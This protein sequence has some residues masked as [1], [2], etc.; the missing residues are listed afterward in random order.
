M[1][2]RIRSYPIMEEKCLDL[3]QRLPVARLKSMHAAFV[4]AGFHGWLY[5]RGAVNA[6]R[7]T[8][9]LEHNTDPL[10]PVVSEPTPTTARRSS[11]SREDNPNPW[12]AGVHLGSLHQIKIPKMLPLAKQLTP[13]SQSESENCQAT[14]SGNE[15]VRTEYR[16]SISATES[17]ELPDLRLRGS[18]KPMV[19]V[20][21]Q[22]LPRSMP[23]QR[24]DLSMETEATPAG[25]SAP[26]LGGAGSARRGGN[27]SGRW[28]RD[29]DQNFGNAGASKILHV[30]PTVVLDNRLLVPIEYESVSMPPPPGTT[31]SNDMMNTST[32]TNTCKP[33]AETGKVEAG[34]SVPLVTANTH[35][36]IVIRIRLPNTAWSEYCQVCSA[37]RRLLNQSLLL[38]D[39][40]GRALQVQAQVVRRE[41]GTMW[42]HLSAFYWMV[43][44]T[45]NPLEWQFVTRAMAGDVSPSGSPSRALYQH[46]RSATVPKVH[47]LMPGSHPL[48]IDSQEVSDMQPAPSK[49]TRSPGRGER[50]TGSSSNSDVGAP[51]V[52]LRFR[53]EGQG[54]PWSDP[55]L[56]EDLLLSGAKQI[57]CE[58]LTLSCSV[59]RAAAPFPGHVCV[60][61]IGPHLLI[62]N[63]LTIPLAVWQMP[64]PELRSS[65]TTPSA[66][67]LLLDNVPSG[68]A[69]H[70][71][72]RAPT[73]RL[74]IA[75]GSTAQEARLGESTAAIFVEDGSSEL[76]LLQLPGTNQ[77]ISAEIAVLPGSATKLVRFGP[78]MGRS[79]YRIANKSMVS[80]AVRQWNDRNAPVLVVP[81]S[82]MD[83]V[84]T[85][86]CE[87]PVV[88]VWHCGDDGP[89]DSAVRIHM[90]NMESIGEMIPLATSRGSKTTSVGMQQNYVI[91]RV[92]PEGFSH[93]MEI[94]E[95]SDRWVKGAAATVSQES[96]ELP[97][98][99]AS[100]SIRSL[101]LLSVEGAGEAQRE[102]LFV[103]LN[104]AQCVVSSG[105]SS[106]DITLHVQGIQVDNL[107]PTTPFPVLAMVG[108]PK[109][110][111]HGA[112][113][114]TA[115][116]LLLA[117]NLCASGAGTMF[118]RNCQI[119]VSPVRVFLERRI[120]HHM[121]ELAKAVSEWSAPIADSVGGT[122]ND[123]PICSTGMKQIGRHG[124]LAAGRLQHTAPCHLGLS[125]TTA[126]LAGGSMSGI[127]LAA[128]EEQCFNT[129]GNFS[130]YIERANLAPVR[131]EIT[132][133]L[134]GGAELNCA[135]FDTP[136]ANILRSLRTPSEIFKTV[137]KLYIGSWQAQYWELL[138]ALVTGGL[139]KTA[140]QLAA[141]WA[142]QSHSRQRDSSGLTRVREPDGLTRV[143]S[144][145][146]HASTASL[147][148]TS[149][150][151]P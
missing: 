20:G 43:N 103:Y 144:F 137:R 16:W 104:N 141:I 36:E 91:A 86:P 121:Q 82:V 58:P 54:R 24:S 28:F 99:T 14:G 39:D 74:R 151:L 85:D 4:F 140:E 71:Y 13:S 35:W 115:M 69:I 26:W 108:M 62:R 50:R 67:V 18:H 122:G 65:T 125:T 48:M 64:I 96:D 130:V 111:P 15:G 60:C 1:R 79:P 89:A 143:S 78:Y 88:V 66:R 30:A 57:A 126:M 116:S 138:G 112:T 84:W 47:V 136:P 117:Q 118:V 139:K 127:Q 59:E 8:M 34:V 2:A 114:N 98:M 44:T 107:L 147:R 19:A 92:R 129:G 63:A 9:S 53:L 45:S 110:F 95:P 32:D 31:S 123:V 38:N 81:N 52:H 51:C 55:V 150:V 76:T 119:K 132:A 145:E 131:L 41:L 80:V 23:W 49:L 33:V 12:S 93:T 37:S 46:L 106:R 7:S 5:V 94:S 135:Q 142:G 70:C 29:M 148:S 134:G 27:S 90:D 113:A 128:L 42:I 11:L 17:D 3:K 72:G 101:G 105:K 83:I 56:L 102:L 120:L 21:A 97:Q 100:I 109:P 10:N 40:S 149:S 146:S 124:K 87:A 22:D 6:A 68:G 61:T 75:V 25:R 133:K 73:G 77:L